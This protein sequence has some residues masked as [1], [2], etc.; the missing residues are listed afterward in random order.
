MLREFFA[1]TLLAPFFFSTAFGDIGLTEYQDR[2]G[3]IYKEKKSAVVRV[4]G[5][6]VDSDAAEGSQKI[7]TDI[8]T[9]FFISSDGLV[10]SIANVA[11]K[12]KDI[13][14]D[15]KGNTYRA[16]L[17]GYDSLTNISI[18]QV[19]G[20]PRGIEFIQLSEYLQVP[21]V[22]TLFLA[23]TCQFGHEPGPS[24]GMITGQHTAFCDNIIF[25]TTYLRINIP[26]DGGEGGSPVFDMQGRFIGMMAISVNNS[27][28]SFVVPSRAILRVR[29]DLIFSGRAAYAYFGIELD[30]ELNMLDPTKIVVGTAVKGGP[31]HEAGVLP[32]DHILEFNE[33]PIGNVNDLHNAL[34]FARPGQIL[35]LKLVRN[36]Q[37]M[38]L[39]VRMMEIEAAKVAQEQKE[40]TA[41]KENTERDS[42][43]DSLVKVDKKPRKWHIFGTL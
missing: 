12:A 29:D 18:L 19:E 35:N 24:N 5:Q 10:M 27:R 42:P 20:L 25:P 22:A 17:M 32:G 9:G 14:I 1:I 11:E 26:H 31:A 37:E 43:E 39:P 30:R 21:E 23:I 41:K 6:Y 7:Q 33:T 34:F 3:K 36:S 2:V 4:L 8:C 38:T 13:Y 15:Y 40:K 16:V 28:S